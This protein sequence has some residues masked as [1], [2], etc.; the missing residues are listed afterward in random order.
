MEMRRYVESKL[1]SKELF[2]MQFCDVRYRTVIYRSL[3]CSWI[4]EL[5]ISTFD[6]SETYYSFRIKITFWMWFVWIIDIEVKIGGRGKAK[7]WNYVSADPV[8]V[9]VASTSANTSLSLGVAVP[10]GSVCSEGKWFIFNILPLFNQNL[11]WGKVWKPF[12]NIFWAGRHGSHNHNRS[13]K[14]ARYIMNALR[15]AQSQNSIY[16]YCVACYSLTHIYVWCEADELLFVLC[17][18][19]ISLN[20]SLSLV[21][22]IVILL[23]G[24]N[25]K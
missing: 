6:R 15:N 4:L 7:T 24:W 18:V 16:Q 1:Y 12:L 14:W 9:V 8:P 13:T 10:S 22:L 11:S 21:N 3:F 25:N 17:C 20:V 2:R 5:H 23:N 19:S